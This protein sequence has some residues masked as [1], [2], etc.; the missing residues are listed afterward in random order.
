MALSFGALFSLPYLVYTLFVRYNQHRLVQIS[1]VFAFPAMMVMVELAWG[2]VSP[3]GELS[4]IIYRFKHIFQAAGF[5]LVT[6]MSRTYT[7]FSWYL[8]LVWVA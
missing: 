8:T 1:S 6:T 3:F 4:H 2:Y 7:Y 5:L